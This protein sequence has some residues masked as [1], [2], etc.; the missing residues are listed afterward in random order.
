MEK[1]LNWDHEIN[2]TPLEDLFENLCAASHKFTGRAARVRVKNKSHL[3]IEQL[4]PEKKE[5]TLHFAQGAEFES[6]R[7]EAEYWKTVVVLS[8]YNHG[9]E[10][11]G[12][13]HHIVGNVNNYALGMYVDKEI[14]KSYHENK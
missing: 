13:L 1:L 11:L 2:S 8:L 9:R 7:V 10:T 14:N 6:I 12:R 4:I 5:R 3:V